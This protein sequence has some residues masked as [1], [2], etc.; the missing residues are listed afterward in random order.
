MLRRAMGKLLVQD[1]VAALDVLVESAML[2]HYRIWRK[3]GSKLEI[4][5]LE[6]SLFYSG[7]NVRKESPWRIG[8]QAL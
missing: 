1:V 2:A 4:P 7:R 8:P 6:A 5:S 3:P